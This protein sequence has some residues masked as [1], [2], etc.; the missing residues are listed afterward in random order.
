VT[1]VLVRYTARIRADGALPD[2]VDAADYDLALEHEATLLQA[3]SALKTATAALD[4]VWLTWSSVDRD[5]TGDG[6]YLAGTIRANA[7]H[8]FPG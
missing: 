8:S 7:L 1:E 4:G 5:V 6:T 2:V 3:V